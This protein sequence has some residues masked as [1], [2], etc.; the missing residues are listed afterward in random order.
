MIK[1][2]MYD[3]KQKADDAFMKAK[4]SYSDLILKSN[5]KNGKFILK[6]GDSVYFSYPGS[7]PFQ[8]F[9]GIIMDTVEWD[10]NSVFDEDFKTWLEG[11]LR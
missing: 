10:E 4:E 9:Q 5:K 2:R 6:N 3:R 7:K 1:Y 11:R 8:V